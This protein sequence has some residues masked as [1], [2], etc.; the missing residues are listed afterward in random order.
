MWKL[1]ERPKGERRKSVYPAININKGGMFLN[2]MACEMIGMK[3]PG[4]IR[5]FLFHYD[6]NDKNRYGFRVLKNKQENLK[7]Q[8]RVKYRHQNK[9]AKINVKQFIITFDLLERTRKVEQTTFP[10]IKDNK[11]GEDF[12]Y[13]ELK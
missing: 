6:D 5:F 4:D 12:Y 1:Y 3:A 2:H 10:L 9:T 7:N 11:E 8:Y 13:F